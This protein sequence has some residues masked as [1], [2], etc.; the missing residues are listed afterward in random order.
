MSQNPLI[1][2]KLLEL[3]T[4]QYIPYVKDAILWLETYSGE[5]SKRSIYEL[6]NALD[7][8]GIALQKDTTEENAI[9]SLNA[10]E[11]HFRRAAVEPIEWIAL[12]EMRYL[13]KIQKRGFWW[14]RLLLLKPIDTKEFNEEI[15]KGMECMQKGR[16]Y[17]GVS[18]KDSYENLKEAYNV[19]HSLLD[20]VKPAEL[21]SRIFAVGLT[22]ISLFIGWSIGLAIK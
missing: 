2:N 8:I 17:K 10:V 22:F 14:W 1:V 6:R 5:K 11:E 20:K 19:F 12:E 7:H 13:L 9:K 16:H 3:L 4:T 21:R 15:Y 18:L